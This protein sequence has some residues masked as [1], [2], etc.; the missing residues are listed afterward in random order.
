MPFNRLGD[1][2]AEVDETEAMFLGDKLPTRST[3]EAKTGTYSWLC[4]GTTDYWGFG[5][6]AKAGVRAAQHQI[7]AP[8]IPGG[9]I[10]VFGM[11]ETLTS[12]WP[13]RV[14]WKRDEFRWDLYVNNVLEDQVATG[15]IGIN[16]PAIWY[17]VAMTMSNAGGYCSVYL[18]G[19]QVL[20]FTGAITSGDIDFVT[21]LRAMQTNSMSPEFQYVDNFYADEI[22]AESDQVPPGYEFMPSYVDGADTAQWTL[23][24]AATNWQ[25]V[26]DGPISDGDAT[27]NK[28]NT[29]GGALE[30]RHETVD[31]VLPTDYIIV[32]AHSFA[33]AKKLDP[34]M[35]AQIELSAHD[36]ITGAYSPSP[37]ELP[38]SYQYMRERFVT[39]PDASNWNELD[40]NASYFGYRASGSF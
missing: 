15:D 2:H 7:S 27:Y 29:S 9:D 3:V 1:T 6:P 24:G 26:D 13:H 14:E 32:A 39:Q 30:D 16:N 31:I 35:D 4:S 18:D 36:G 8:A 33:L 38:I 28:V 10:F 22:D 23:Q 25:C 19:V 21:S 17:H 34:A 11:H 5:F 40:F 12:A 20:N 37:L